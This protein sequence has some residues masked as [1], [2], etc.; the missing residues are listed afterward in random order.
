VSYYCEK[1]GEQREQ[2]C[3]ARGCPGIPEYYEPIK[4]GSQDDRGCGGVEGHAA[5]AAQRVEPRLPPLASRPKKGKHVAGVE[6]GPHPR[7]PY[8]PSR[9]T[10][11][12]PERWLPAALENGCS[13]PYIWPE[14]IARQ[15]PLAGERRMIRRAWRKE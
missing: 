15:H 3:F 14:H 11:A 9:V 4:N 2:G 7:S 13:Y 5:W 1:C 8:T 12:V 6:S 10:L